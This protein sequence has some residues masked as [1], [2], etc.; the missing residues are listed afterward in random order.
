MIKQIA[1]YH[2]TRAVPDRQDLVRMQQQPAQAINELL[3]RVAMIEREAAQKI[4]KTA[5]L[6]TAEIADPANFDSTGL[7]VNTFRGLAICNG[8]NGTPEIAHAYRSDQYEH[9]VGDTGEPAFENSWVN[10][11][12][13]VYGYTRFKKLS[14]GR[15][16]ISGLVKSGVS[17]T[18]FTLPSGYTP[19]HQCWFAGNANAA[20]ASM[21]VTSDGAVRRQTGSN[22]WCSLEGIQFDT[23]VPTSSIVPLMVVSS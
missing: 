23:V 16:V 4:I 21:T 15:V 13:S 3:A 8:N 22:V 10:Y 14:N 18:I 17:T 6:T 2:P 1:A 9:I 11:D 12:T 19:A 5:W 7:G 20:F